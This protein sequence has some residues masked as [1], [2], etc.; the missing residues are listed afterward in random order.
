M[1]EEQIK[2]A[3]LKLSVFDSF[4]YKRL[5]QVIN[6]IEELGFDCEFIDNGNIVFTDKLFVLTDQDSRG[7]Q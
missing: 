6:A 5:K 2:K 4:P 1:N 3:N 7:K